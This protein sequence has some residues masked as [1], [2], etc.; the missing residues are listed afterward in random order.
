MLIACYCKM[1][2]SK[3]KPKSGCGNRAGLILVSVC[4]AVFMIEMA[5][6][7]IPG[8][9]PTEIMAIFQDQVYQPSGEVI[10]HP[11]LGYTY[12][13][14]L[15]NHPSSIEDEGVE[16]TYSVS[17]VSLGYQGVGFRDDG[18]SG[19]TFAITIGDSYTSCVGVEMDACW[20]EYLETATHHDFANLG[21]IAYSPQQEQQMLAQYGLPLKP[22]LVLW[23]FYSNDINDAW[24]FNQFGS[25]AIEGK[26]W[27]NPV[28]SWLAQNSIGYRT[29]AFFWY[30]R[31]LFYNLATVDRETTPYD[32][33]LIWLLTYTDLTVP[34]VTEGFAFTKEAILAAH[35]ETQARLKDTPFVVVIIPFR[36]QVYY[37]EA[38]L[39]QHLDTLPNALANFCQQNNIPVIDLTPAIRARYKADPMPLYFGKDIH[40]NVAG[41]QLVGE[42]LETELANYYP[43]P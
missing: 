8:L 34:E 4:F 38:M 33:N 25:G 21:V 2:L 42:L 37:T 22:K 14:N 40:L 20:V 26:F 27:Q 30:N 1:A 17:T 39:P 12:A 9:I 7:L 28:K 18:I 6:R 23:I 41:N 11:K 10:L 13:P 16:H 32:T 31:Y 29:L 43:G 5:G 36:E 15:V 3:T 35:K 24:R 19:E